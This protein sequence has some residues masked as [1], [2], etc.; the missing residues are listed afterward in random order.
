[1]GR[2]AI[3][4]APVADQ[5]AA[6]E[7]IERPASVVKELVENALDAGATEITIELQ[8]GGR[9]CI[10]VSDDGVGMDS[11][12]ARLAIDR[13]ATSKIRRVADLIGVPTYGFRGEALAAIASVSKFAIETALAENNDGSGEATRVV[14]DGGKSGGVEV[15]ARQRGTTVTVERLFYNTPARRKFLRSQASET[16]AVV[17]AVTVLA[18]ARLDVAFKLLSDKRTLID[19]PRTSDTVERIEALFGRRMAESLVPV[20]YHSG[21]LSVRGFVQRPAD[22]KPTGRKAFLFVNGRPFR[23]PFLVRA[24]EAGY[25][26][27]INPGCRPTMF[28]SLGLPGDAVDVNVHP[29]KLEVRFRDRRFVEGS[30]EEGVRVALGGFGSAA[31]VWGGGEGSL[32][33]APSARSNFPSADERAATVGWTG[34][35]FDTAEVGTTGAAA[36]AP[37]G[38]QLRELLQVF[39]TYIVL[40][41]PEGVAFVDQ[42]SA[43]E[44]ILYEEALTQLKGEGAAAQ[45]LLLPL[46]IDLDAR[47]FEA[48]EAN[49]DLLRAIGYEIDECGGRSVVVHAVP[50]PHPRFDA[51]R[52][53]EELAADMARGRFGGWANRLER[54]AATYA[55]RA[56]IKAGHVLEAGERRHLLNRLFACEL[57]PHDVHGRP[58]I[59]QLPRDELEKRFGRS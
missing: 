13:H 8:G 4:P 57:P 56:A 11:D 17:Q 24:A 58:T 20:D 39:R 55:C 26:A 52:C 21:P 50:N 41:T 27:T 25:R 18:L 10:A 51:K 43:H 19:V 6:G 28:L 15:T 45:R 31:V 42:H 44:R 49:R 29:T 46:T 32:Q 37:I 36:Q 54:F 33:G 9:T 2:I 40:E 59:V 38:D 16:R 7:V 22:A 3:L 5:I 23:D 35:M 1:V 30:V 47:E 48:V 12:D 53:C 34:S 14:V